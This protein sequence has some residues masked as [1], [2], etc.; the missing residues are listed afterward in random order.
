M[1]VS[2]RDLNHGE[3][4]SSLTYFVILL[5]VCMSDLLSSG[6]N[7][8]DRPAQVFFYAVFSINII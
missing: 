5:F 3:I 8:I 4:Y 2:F 6:S 1:A 7:V